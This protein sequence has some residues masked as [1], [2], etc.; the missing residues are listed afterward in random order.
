MLRILTTTFNC[1]NYISRCIEY[2]IK[3]SVEDWICY[4]MDDLS[5][6]D[7]PK[8]LTK[9]KDERFIIINNQEKKYQLGNYYEIIQRFDSDDIC[10]SLDGDDYFT[11]NQVLKRV[12]NEY[13]NGAWVTWGSCINE[14]KNEIIHQEQGDL[15][16]LRSS[17]WTPFHLRT[18]KVFLWRQINKEDLMDNGNFW[19]VAG[20]LAFMYPMIEMAGSHA[21]YLK[22]ISYCYNDEN[23][24]CNHS[25]NRKMQLENDAKIRAKI[26]YCA[27]FL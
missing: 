14:S 21:K 23:P 16:N 1:E 10:I 4:V 3:Q 20:D 13:E 24:N 2:L 27:K 8:I 12:L 17:L 5:T 22:E 19:T 26:P 6:D 9:I 7:T 18:W 25:K 15:I 11:D